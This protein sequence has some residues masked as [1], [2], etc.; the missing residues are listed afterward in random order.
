MTRF[1]A[2]MYNCYLAYCVLIDSKQRREAANM[3]VCATDEDFPDIVQEITQ[4]V[5]VVPQVNVNSM[6]IRLKVTTYPGASYFSVSYS[7]DFCSRP[8]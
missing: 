8:C 2:L 7:A 3:S 5:L 4:N 1:L 6:K